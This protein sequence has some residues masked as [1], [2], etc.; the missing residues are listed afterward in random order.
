MRW[1]IDVAEVFWNSGGTGRRITLKLTGTL[2]W[3]GFGLGFEAQT[4]PA[5]KCPVERRVRPHHFGRLTAKD[6]DTLPV[7][8]EP[9][10]LIGW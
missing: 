5:A 7:F 9:A 8:I 4:W 6:N 3:A 2:R 1:Y 10:E